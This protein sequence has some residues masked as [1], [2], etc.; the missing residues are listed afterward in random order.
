MTISA[1]S[2][3]IGR[4]VFGVAT[5]AF[6]II[7]LAWHNY[8][9]W[10]QL[11]YLLNP[12]DGPVFLYAVAAAQIF[13][14]VAIQF[15]R[16][17]KMGAVVLGAVYLVFAL[18]C[19]P[20]IV[21]APTVY[22]SWGSFFEPFSLLTGAAIVYARL[23]STL[24]PATLNRIGRI[25]F[26]VCTISFTFE[27]AFYLNATAK[28]VPTWLPP[29]QMFWAIAT[30][31]AF[32]L[33]GAALLTNRMA[34]LAIRLLTLMIVMFGLVVWVPLLLSNPHSHGNWSEFVDTFAIAG[35]AWIVADLLGEYRPNESSPAVT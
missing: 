4:H 35:A 17:A 33:A 19:V 23:S 27:Q 34:L 30:T 5:L 12:T 7:T 11:R 24:P 8:K 21:T 18:L 10:D 15:R 32:G 14:G 29:S 9:D 20:P 26:G 3:N 13:G 6:G 1:R 16:T 2:L 22:N 25:L 31:V 28:L